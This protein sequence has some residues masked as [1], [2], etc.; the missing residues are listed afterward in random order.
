M[1]LPRPSLITLMIVAA[2]ACVLVTGL[3]AL[4]DMLHGAS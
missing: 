3:I 1:K 2:V 4:R